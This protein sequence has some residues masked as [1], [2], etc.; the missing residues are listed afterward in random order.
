MTKLE[1]KDLQSRA[2][3]SGMSLKDGRLK[4]DNNLAEN[5]IR[6]ITLGR[7]NYLFCGNH[8]SA[9]NMCVIQSLLVTC[10]NHDIN[11]RLY[12]NS[13]IEAMPRFEKATEEELQVLLPHKWKGFHPEAIMSTPVRQLVK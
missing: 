7:K 4:L 8:E 9:E 10:R 5:E 6:P 11:A 13:V 3:S 1:F 2:A 12:L